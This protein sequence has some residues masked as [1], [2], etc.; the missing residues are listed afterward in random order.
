MFDHL[1]LTTF[2]IDGV[3]G[4]D[5]TKLLYYGEKLAP[6]LIPRDKMS[7]AEIM[8]HLQEF[9]SLERTAMIY[10]RV[11]GN[12]LVEGLT[13]KPLVDDKACLEMM[14]ALS[15]EDEVAD[16]YVEHTLEVINLMT[17]GM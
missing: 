6:A 15:V 11:R 5:G 16:I 17:K 4:R 1:L 2:H 3:F 14:A 7:V 12:S 8:R 9:T 13:L 10:W